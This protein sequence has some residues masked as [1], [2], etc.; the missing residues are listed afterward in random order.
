M[1]KKQNKKKTNKHKTTWYKVYWVVSTHS[2]NFC[3]I[4]TGII[5]ILNNVTF[6]L[7]HPVVIYEGLY[8]DL[9][10]GQ[11]NGAPNETR[12]HSCRFASLTC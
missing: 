10:Q 2:L 4:W 9:A 11:M 1:K 3:I 8:F 7:K 6:F 5:Q 12:T